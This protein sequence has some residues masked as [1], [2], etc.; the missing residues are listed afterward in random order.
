[1]RT[2]AVTYP[3]TGEVVGE[4]PLRPREEIRRTLDR[5]GSARVR[6]DRHE[7]AQVLERIAARIEAEA[8]EL[9]RAITLESGLSLFDTRH[10]TGRAAD[11]FRFAAHAAL[12]DDGQAFACDVSAHGRPRRAY[13]LREPVRLVAAITPFNHPLNQVAHKVAPAIAAGAPIVLKPSEKTPLAALW[14]ENAVRES[15]YPEEACAIVTGDRAEILDEMLAHDAVEVVSFTGGVGVGRE[16]ARRLGYRRAVLELGGNDPL[17]VLRDADVDRAAELAVTGATRNSGQRCTAVKRIVVEEPLADALAE[18]V[19]ARAA[20]LSVGD[21]L[22]DATDIGTLVDEA[23]AETVERRVRAAADDG[24]SLLAGGERNG[25]Q[26]VPPVLDRVR[27]EQELVLEET[28]G[29][30]IPLVR[31]RDLDEALAVANG[32]AYG[33]SAGIVS[34][35]LAAVTRCIRELRCGSVNVDEVPGFRTEATPFGGV[36][37]SGLGIKEGVIEAMR[38]MTTVKLFTLPWP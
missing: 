21:P 4:A 7:R 29:P 27:P 30:A 11:V 35:D 16:I 28:F 32:T 25:A 18:A 13:T 36:K 31:V 1:M 15:G 17:I 19:T 26:I 22:S 37:A 8:E 14:L 20:A 12:D 9:A 5:A 3:Y 2:F 10:E 33:L 6:L 34:N 23:A 38:G 24:A